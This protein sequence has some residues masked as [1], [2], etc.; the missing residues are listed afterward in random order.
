MSKMNHALSPVHISDLTPKYSKSR[1]HPQQIPSIKSLKHPLTLL[2]WI[3]GG[4]SI[5]HSLGCRLCVVTVG[6]SRR[7]DALVRV[8]GC[9]GAKGACRGGCGG[10]LRGQMA[11]QLAS[12]P[13]VPDLFSTIRIF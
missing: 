10:N 2:H 1:C 8:R 6:L 3:C 5:W 9:R 13:I 11:C 12:C 4:L 7:A